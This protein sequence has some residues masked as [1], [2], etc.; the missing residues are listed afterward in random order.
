MKDEERLSGEKLSWIVIASF[1][2]AIGLAFMGAGLLSDPGTFDLGDS[3]QLFLDWMTWV[4]WSLFTVPI[5]LLAQRIGRHPSRGAAMIFHILAA[6]GFTLLHLTTYLLLVEVVRGP[7]PGG[8]PEILALAA[9][10]LPRHLLYN[11]LIYGAIVLAGYAAHQYW[12]REMRNHDEALMERLVAEAELDLLRARIQP[13]LIVAT[14][15]AISRLVDQ[16][17][18]RAEDAILRLSDFLRL[19][20][21]SGEQEYSTVEDEVVTV[22]AWLDVLKVATPAGRFGTVIV[23]TSALHCPMPP[24]FLQTLVDSA[25][26]IE[27]NRVFDLEIARQEDQLSIRMHIGTLREGLTSD[28]LLDT[29]ESVLKR[30][31]G[32]RFRLGH[33]SQAGATDLELWLPI[34]PT[35]AASSAGDRSDS[36]REREL[37]VERWVLPGVEG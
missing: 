4:Q 20:L 2:P 1:W 8:L 9:V 23:G 35:D 30:A 18:A 21:T 3:R 29:V 27:R 22:H 14:L 11:P 24:A 31:Y 28:P 6:A 7:H 36:Q 32:N 17:V 26:G 15:A 19:C 13:P 37:P 12:C 33:R 16:D 34:V 5:L 10:R 25:I